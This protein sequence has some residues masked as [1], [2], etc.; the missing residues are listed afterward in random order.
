MDDLAH[1]R[2]LLSQIHATEDFPQMQFGYANFVG[3]VSD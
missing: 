1:N 2:T 3:S